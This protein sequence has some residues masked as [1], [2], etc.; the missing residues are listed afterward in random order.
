MR[1]NYD[2]KI[3]VGLKNEIIY[4]IDSENVHKTTEKEQL[5]RKESEFKAKDKGDLKLAMEM[6]YTPKNKSKI[7]MFSDANEIEIG[8][9]EPFLYGNSRLWRTLVRSFPFFD[10]RERM[11]PQIE[12]LARQIIEKRETDQKGKEE[13]TQYK[14]Q[15]AK[16]QS[17]MEILLQKIEKLDTLDDVNRRILEKLMDI[18]SKTKSSAD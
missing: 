9:E 3:Y 1:H 4:F 13:Q 17:N 15:V 11:N 18:D 7:R 12:Q 8:F 14:E 10:E 6:L 16:I 2:R 5:S